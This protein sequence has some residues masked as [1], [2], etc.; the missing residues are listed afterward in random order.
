[1]S[2][3]TGS[4]RPQRPTRTKATGAWADGDRTPLNH[5]EEFK[6]ADDGLN[7]RQRILD[8]YS[9]EGF[10]SIAPDDLSGRM[11]WWGLYTQRR[12]GLDASH[13]GE[14]GLDD[15]YFMMRIRSDGGALTTEQLRVIAG[16]STDFARGTAD[17]SDRQNIQLHW[18]RVEDVPE[19]WERLEAVDLGTTQ[20]CGDVPRV[21]LG[22]PVAGIAADEIIDGTP[23]LDEIRRRYLGSPEY[24]N[25][26]RKFK[27]AVSGSPSLDVAHEINDVSFVGVEHPELGPGFDL[28]V[29]GG[30]STN[31]MFAQRLGAFVTLEEVPDVWAGVCGIFRD[32][33]YRRLRNRARLKFLVA[34]WGPE[35]FRAVLE[36]DYLGRALPD[37]P[38]PA[39][40]DALR[41]DHVGVHP[42]RDGRVW[43]GVAAI[44]GRV[45]GEILA[46]V[47]DAAEAAGSG[48]VRLTPHQKLLV[49][50]V[51]PDAAEELVTTLDG[52]GLS[53]RP[54]EWRRGVMACTGIEYCKL[55]LTETKARARW[56]VE[57]LERRLPELDVPFSIHVNGCPN[58]CARSQVAD[59]GLKGMVAQDE[60]G[61]IVDMY[62]VHLGGSLG[63]EPALA[64][65]TRALKVRADELPDYVERITRTYLGQREA[66]E[67]F[68]SWARRA[69]EEDIR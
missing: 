63:L 34:D 4:E 12:Q 11:R 33:G 25:L 35:R 5:N 40:P 60:D 50:D 38:A 55:A 13:T 68:A 37:G 2:V 42:Q 56:T 52:L 10:A 3:T 26:P 45:S 30:L 31:P 22:S 58:S 44:G 23:A 27:T 51:E 16:I 64:R 8:T 61:A 69:D 66:G 36:Q 65:K 48:R 14:D 29:G 15:E 57:E 46:A 21:A 17:I 62:Q 9:R 54:S 49:L 59:V 53:A 1:M 67:S 43:V 7:V 19:I 41:R 6:Q 20:A 32:H 18:V 24:S 28:W 47:A 39:S